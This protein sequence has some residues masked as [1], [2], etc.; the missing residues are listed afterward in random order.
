MM[1][2]RTSAL[3]L[4]LVLG[5]PAG[6]ACRDMTFEDQPYTVC[7]VT[8]AE[9]L[10][11]FQTGP[12][13][14]PFGSFD[15][16]NTGLAAT[17]QTLGFAMNAGMYHRDRAPVGLLIEDGR[18][19]APVIT[20]D[21]P[22]NF[23]LLPNGVFCV[24]RGRFAVIESRTYAKAPPDCRHA[25]QSGPMLVIHGDLHPRFLPGSESL[26]IRNG[27]G[28]SADGSRAV[29]AISGRPVNFHTFARLF[30]DGL[31]LPDALYLDG[32]ISRLY[33]PG[34][35]RHDAGLPM[36]PIVGTVVPVN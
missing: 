7:Q 3:L 12:A 25:T 13:G 16:V 34:L 26:N 15:A 2:I 5:G 6:A 9:D 24:L 18:E 35:N 33:A 29:F 14:E 4:A 19:R 30:R 27:V 31:D 36:G 28:V 23:G 20:S 21:G 32:S 10:R 17:G 11:L 8:P 1:P 22:G